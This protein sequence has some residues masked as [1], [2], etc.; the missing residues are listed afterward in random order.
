MA[1]HLIQLE[2][3]RPYAEYFAWRNGGWTVAP[4]NAPGYRNGYCRLCERLWEEEQLPKVL[5]YIDCSEA[6]VHLVLFLNKLLVKLSYERT[7]KAAFI[8]GVYAAVHTISGYLGLAISVM[9][10]DVIA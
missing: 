2:S 7:D 4:W 1:E 8:V 6:L 9:V 10:R 3:D 5:D